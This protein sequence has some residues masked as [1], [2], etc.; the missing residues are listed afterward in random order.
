MTQSYL[1]NLITKP[2]GRQQRINP[3]IIK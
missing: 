3:I 1:S 2:N